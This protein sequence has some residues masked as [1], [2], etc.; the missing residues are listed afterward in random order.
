MKQVKIVKIHA[1]QYMK[2]VIFL[3]LY[4]EEMPQPAEAGC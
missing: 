4:R 1:S 3:L 2:H